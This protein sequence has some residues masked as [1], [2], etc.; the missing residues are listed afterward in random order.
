MSTSKNMNVEG[1]LGYRLK[2]TQHALRIAMDE[3]IKSI[4]LTTPQYAVLAQLELER[5]L[6]NAE[7]ARSSF[8]PPQTTPG[9]VSN[10]E[11]RGLIKRKKS[12]A[13]GR[14]LLLEL[15]KKGEKILSSAHSMIKTVETRMVSTIKDEH[16]VQLENLLLECFNNL[17]ISF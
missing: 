1:L 4:D 8:I 7:L 15:T 3:A 2:K 10:L 9:I 13:H 11:N 17:N 14:I 12:S 5:G 6:S 16:K